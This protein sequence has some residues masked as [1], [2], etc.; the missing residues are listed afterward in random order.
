MTK[1]LIDAYN[2]DVLNDQTSHNSI[3]NLVPKWHAEGPSILGSLLGSESH[4]QI[5][6]V[7]WSVP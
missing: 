7:N 6:P 2:I 3:K 4:T 1:Y 5:C